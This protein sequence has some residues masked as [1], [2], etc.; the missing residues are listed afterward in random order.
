MAG[1][2]VVDLSANIPSI[3]AGTRGNTAPKRGL[4]GAAGG[5]YVGP[6][7]SKAATEGPSTVTHATGA[8]AGGVEDSTGARESDS[9]AADGKTGG[10]TGGDSNSVT[11]PTGRTAY[12]GTGVQGGS[13]PGKPFDTTGRAAATGTDRFGRSL[14]GDAYQGGKGAGRFTYTNFDGRSSVAGDG[15][16]AAGSGGRGTTVDGETV[17]KHVGRP[18]ISATAEASGTVAIVAGDDKISVAIHTD[19]LP[20]SAKTNGV[21]GVAGAE[22]IAY[23]RGEDT[24]ENGAIVGFARVGAVGDGVDDTDLFTGLANTTAYATYVRW[25]YYGSDGKLHA[26]PWSDRNVVTTT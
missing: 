19:D 25:V 10:F 15:G 6:V 7:L 14:T 4:R 2:T 3:A 24:D 9:Y 22:V 13:T 11:R 12:L 23:A 26:G 18:T 8:A 5:V 16:R 17:T 20:P 21:N 1:S